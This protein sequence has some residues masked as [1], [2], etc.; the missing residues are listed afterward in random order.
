MEVFSTIVAEGGTDNLRVGLLAR[1]VAP[2]TNVTGT[3]PD[4]TVA[5][6]SFEGALTQQLCGMLNVNCTVVPIYDLANR[7]RALASGGVDFLVAQQT[8]VD[9]DRQ[10]MQPV[11][12]FYYAG[13]LFFCHR[14]AGSPSAVC[15]VEWILRWAAC[16][17][18][19]Y[20]LLLQ[21]VR[22]ALRVLV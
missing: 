17:C 20:M 18:M 4:V 9:A 11:E 3:W 10:A 6:E 14:R 12:P 2:F 15:C 21:A 19:R 1:P 13:K 22:F 16:C 7:S 8:L 5:W